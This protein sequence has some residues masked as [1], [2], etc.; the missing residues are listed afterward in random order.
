MFDEM[1]D[2]K[3]IAEFDSYTNEQWTALS[4]VFHNDVE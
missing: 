4:E 2:L 3:E 1:P